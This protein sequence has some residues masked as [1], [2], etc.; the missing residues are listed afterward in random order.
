MALVF[1]KQNQECEEL[2][3]QVPATQ[4]GRRDDAEMEKKIRDLLTGHHVF[5]RREGAYLS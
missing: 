4:R 3:G 1:K 5:G 2:K